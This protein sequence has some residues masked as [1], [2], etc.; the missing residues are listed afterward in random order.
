MKKLLLTILMVSIA[1]ISNADCVPEIKDV[2]KDVARN[3]IVI[4][5]EYVLN[6]NVVDT[7]GNT[8]QL[9]SGKYMSGSA[10]CIGELRY[11]RKSGTNAFIVRDAKK[12]NRIHC[13]SLLRRIPVNEEFIKTQLNARIAELRSGRTI[14]G[15][16]SSIKGD[17]VGYTF[18]V[19]EADRIYRGR[20]INVKADSTNSISDVTE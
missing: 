13:R 2:V 11:S 10:E 4:Q 8:C 15:I 7:N 16:I 6:G 18:I 5:S 17:L 12:Q 3:K 9:I 20:K 1:T 19:T 14:D